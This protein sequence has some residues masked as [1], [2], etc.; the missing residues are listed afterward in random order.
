MYDGM[1]YVGTRFEFILRYGQS[2]GCKELIWYC[3][4]PSLGR[5]YAKNILSYDYIIISYF[6]N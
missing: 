2:D 5:I 3:N 6:I 1:I 4:I